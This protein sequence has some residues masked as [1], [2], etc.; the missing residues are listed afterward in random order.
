MTRMDGHVKCQCK[1][2]RM[3]E[4]RQDKTTHDFTRQLKNAGQTQ[5]TDRRYK[6][7]ASNQSKT[8]NNIQKLTKSSCKM[9]MNFDW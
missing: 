1:A 8:Q 7:T 4:N 5:D 9:K 3:D 6:T 2:E